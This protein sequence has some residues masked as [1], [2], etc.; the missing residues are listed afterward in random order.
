[1]SDWEC[2]FIGLKIWVREILEEH[3]PVGN[4]LCEVVDNTMQLVF[5]LH[6]F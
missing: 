6:L 1:M 4:G 2:L 5:P 3:E